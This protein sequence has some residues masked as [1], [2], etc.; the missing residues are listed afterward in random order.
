M[1]H[2]QFV[3]LNSELIKNADKDEESLVLSEKDLILRALDEEEKTAVEKAS[4]YSNVIKNR[5]MY[6]KRMTV[7]DWKGERMKER[8]ASTPKNHA[9][10]NSRDPPKE[11]ITGLTAAQE[12]GLLRRLIT[13]IDDLAEY[14]YVPNFPAAEDVDKARKGQETAQGWE[15]CDRCDKRFQVFPGRREEDG[16]LASGGLCTHHWG[17]MYFPEQAAGDRSKQPKRYKC[18]GQSVGT[19]SSRIRP[20]ITSRQ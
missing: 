15:Q 2:D 18:C 5:I 14:G 16:A 3:R 7:L 6:Y 20:Q 11:I 19:T 1:L 17:K 13:P 10:K 12:V 9:E 8:K 4:I